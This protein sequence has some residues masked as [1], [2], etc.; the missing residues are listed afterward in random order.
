MF[1]IVPV[2]VKGAVN[3]SDIIYA[4]PD[5]PGTAVSGSKIG[6]KPTL[7]NDAAIGMAFKPMHCNNDEVGR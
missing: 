3:K 1:G 6:F 4:S 2:R 7:K 5:V